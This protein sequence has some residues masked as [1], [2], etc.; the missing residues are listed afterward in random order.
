MLHQ[1]RPV[2]V[3]VSSEDRRIRGRRSSETTP[4]RNPGHQ[5]GVY[6][7]LDTCQQAELISEQVDKSLGMRI[8][9]SLFIIHMVYTTMAI[10][11]HC[12]FNI[13]KSSAT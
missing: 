10:I 1:S 12:Y 5:G 7:C 13:F 4:L 2:R 6:Y 11:K 8:D 3:K 9:Q